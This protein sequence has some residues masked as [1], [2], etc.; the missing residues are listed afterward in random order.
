[1]D[2]QTTNQSTKVYKTISTQYLSWSKNFAKTFAMC[3]ERRSANECRLELAAL[4][5]WR[6]A[7]ARNPSAALR[8]S[9]DTYVS[10]RIPNSHFANLEPGRSCSPF[11]SILLHTQPSGVSSTYNYRPRRGYVYNI[12]IY[13]WL[14]GEHSVTIRDS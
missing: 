7:V 2:Q 10:A 4:P 9:A 5:A 6:S 12:I 11:T 14:Q 8:A 3:Q 1:M 13:L